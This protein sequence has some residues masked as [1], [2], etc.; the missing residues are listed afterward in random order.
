MKYLESKDW[1]WDKEVQSRMLYTL[2]AISCQIANMVR[3]KGA[4]AIKPPEQFQPDYV[5]EAKK[6][7]E[8]AKKQV[9]REDMEDLK[10]I[11]EA[12]NNLTK[13]L[14]V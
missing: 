1:T 3:K 8:R 7:I 2:N 11:F 4:K 5:K 13:K 6:N 12:R 10:E 9:N 14:E